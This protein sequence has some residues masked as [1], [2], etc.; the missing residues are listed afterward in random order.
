MLKKITMVVA[1]FVA[2]NVSAGTDVDES[3]TVGKDTFCVVI[4]GER[5]CWKR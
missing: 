4:G 5:R 2:C 1:M 3:Q